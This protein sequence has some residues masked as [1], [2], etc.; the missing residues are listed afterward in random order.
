MNQDDEGLN[1]VLTVP[2]M[3]AILSGADIPEAATITNRLWGG[4]MVVGGVL[5]LVGAGALCVV[6]EPTMATKA[7]CVVFGLHGSDTTATGFKQMW[8]GVNMHTATHE[9]VAAVARKLGSPDAT[10][11]NIGVLLDIAVPMNMPIAIGAIAAKSISYRR[12]NL[13]WHEGPKGTRIGGHTIDLHVGKSESE[14]R[15][16]LLADPKLRV[17]ASS[18]TSLE[19]AERAI[20]QVLKANEHVIKGRAIQGWGG[21]LRLGISHD[22]GYVVGH[23]VIR[24]TQQYLP[25]TKVRVILKFETYKGQPFFILTA[26]PIK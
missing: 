13:M 22:V 11:N 18:F 7:G 24:A 16:R 10:A 8:T 21:E 2:Q 17:G 23:G 9:A 26:H 12:I 4:A 6:P 3:A 25:M 5:E 19:V 20:Y 1:I 14:L 15:A